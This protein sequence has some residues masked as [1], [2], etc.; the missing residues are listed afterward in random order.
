MHV[1]CERRCIDEKKLFYVRLAYD[2]RDAE[3]A[4][5]LG[6]NKEIPW[7]LP[8]YTF[9]V[10]ILMDNPRIAIRRFR[11]KRAYKQSARRFWGDIPRT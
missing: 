3:S 9:R 10:K 6:T 7:G 8:L 4:I 5:F 1:F 2:R 11:S